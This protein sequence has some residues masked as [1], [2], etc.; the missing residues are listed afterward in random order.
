MA[1]ENFVVSAPVENIEYSTTPASPPAGTLL[2]YA[3]TDDKYYK[4]T[5]AGVETEI[6]SGSSGGKTFAYWANA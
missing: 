5:S 4:Q 2:T 3:K 6:G 1:D